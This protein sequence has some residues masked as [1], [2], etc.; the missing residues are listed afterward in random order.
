MQKLLLLTPLLFLLSCNG[1]Q[2]KINSA[3]FLSAW[4]DS[5]NTT[6]LYQENRKE[7]KVE[8]LTVAPQK[9]SLISRGPVNRSAAALYISKERATV[10]AESYEVTDDNPITAQIVQ[11]AEQQK[12]EAR[13]RTFSNQRWRLYID[14]N[15]SMEQVKPL[16]KKL[17]EAGIKEI[18]FMAAS[19]ENFSDISIA[20]TKL[21][22]ELVT[23]SENTP[24]DARAQ[25]IA[26]L[27]RPIVIS[28][29]KFQQVFDET[30]NA[31]PMYRDST[32]LAEMVKACIGT[33]QEKVKKMLTLAH[34][35]LC[36][37]FEPLDAKIVRF[38]KGGMTFD[39]TLLWQ[40]AGETLFASDKTTIWF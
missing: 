26:E 1:G 34:F 19:S 11:V 7:Y 31:F 16:L 12:A 6:P 8:L 40:E 14:K 13:N 32:F 36:Y 9:S 29:P 23:V 20:D 27:L 4:V 3:T 21:H 2:P 35:T 39:E 18:C 25:K 24:F 15:C 5:V 17:H 33:D 37:G 10:F 30:A 28:E 38:K 22:R